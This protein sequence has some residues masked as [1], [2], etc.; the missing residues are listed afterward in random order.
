M[1]EYNI[2]ENHLK[3]EKFGRH[4]KY[5]ESTASTNNE[6]KSRLAQGDCH[7]H[8]IVTKNQTNGRG[9]R[10]NQWF[11]VPNKSLTFSIIINQKK[12]KNK[13]ILSIISAIAIIKAIKKIST[14]QCLIKWPN[15]II[16]NN[17]KIGGILIEKKLGYMVVGI[18]INVNE[19]KSDLTMKIKNTSTSLRI[20]NNSLIKLETLLA[21]IL[22]ELE[23]YCEIEN[24]YLINKW[25]AY[26][27]HI[28]KKIKF[29]ENDNMISGIFKGINKNGQ[30]IVNINNKTEFISSGMIEI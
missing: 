18:G 9:R 4:I 8:V 22:N 20:N 10:N 23:K 7:G 12:I 21:Y 30:G 16:L 11:S 2:F 29:Y 19:K 13:K 14:V 24:E 26:C 28:N 1:F 5:F 3:S 27:C 17:Q 6:A 15:D 25:L